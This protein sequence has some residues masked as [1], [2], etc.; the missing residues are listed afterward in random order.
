MKVLAPEHTEQNGMMQAKPRCS[1]GARQAI[2]EWANLSLK[3][4]GSSGLESGK[5]NDQQEVM[6]RA[7]VQTLWLPSAHV[8]V[9]WSLAFCPTVPFLLYRGR[10]GDAQGQELDPLQDGLSLTE[11]DSFFRKTLSGVKGYA[12]QGGRGPAEEA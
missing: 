3:R 2:R 10:C 6:G 5:G 9:H 7:G 12:T 1:T 8:Y 11:H 4:Q